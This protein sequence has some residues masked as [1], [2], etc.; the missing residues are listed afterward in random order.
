[1]GIKVCKNTEVKVFIPARKFMGLVLEE[2][3]STPDMVTDAMIESINRWLKKGNN[4][5][6]YSPSE[7][8]VLV[9]WVMSGN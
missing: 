3:A 5:E 9:G 6:S 4:K 8:N 7:I 1:M 2:L